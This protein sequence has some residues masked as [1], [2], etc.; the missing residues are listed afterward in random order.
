MIVKLRSCHSSIKLAA[1]DDSPQ[2]AVEVTQSCRIET[3]KAVK[4]ESA[5]IF[6]RRGMM[7]APSRSAGAEVLAHELREALPSSPA[8]DRDLAI[9]IGKR[10]VVRRNLCGLSTQQLG[11]R[12]GIDSDEVEAYEQGA[13]RMSCSLL[14]QTAK[15]LN[16]TPRFFFQ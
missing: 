2:L 1:F 10:I 12:L 5:S 11:T 6:L 9:K 8:F 16:T 7:L 4:Y 15:Q 13:K 14:L 3:L